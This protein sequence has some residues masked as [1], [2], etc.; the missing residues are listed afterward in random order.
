M[1]EDVCPSNTSK[2]KNANQRGCPI[3]LTPEDQRRMAEL[4]AEGLTC[5]QIADMFG[6]V[7]SCVSTTLRKLGVKMRVIGIRIPK[8]KHP[9]IIQM[10]E[11]GQS[12]DTIAKEFGCSHANIHRILQIHDVKMRPS[13]SPG[14]FSEDICRKIID[15]YKQGHSQDSIAARF[16][17]GKKAIKRVLDEHKVERRRHNQFQPRF[18]AEDH[19]RMVAMYEQG[20]SLQEIAEDI[21]CTHH[22][23][24][25]LL[26]QLG[27]EKRPVLLRHVITPEDREMIVKLR[28]QGKS[29]PEI[30]AKIGCCRETVIAIMRQLNVPVRIQGPDAYSDEDQQKMVDLYENG[31]STV[32][33]AVGFDCGTGTV[34]QILRK[35]GIKIRPHGLQGLLPPKKRKRMLTMYKEGYS[36]AEIAAKFECNLET[37]AS[38]IELATRKSQ[39]VQRIASMSN[40]NAVDNSTVNIES[41]VSETPPHIPLE[42]FIR[43]FWTDQV[44]AVDVLLLPPDFRLKIMES[45][46]QALVYAWTTQGSVNAR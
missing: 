7:V 10:Y 3:V 36:G 2:S 6:C 20:K 31:I 18:I 28:S 8:E 17:C 27:I 19:Q 39:I 4:Y 15:M 22:T 43:N 16:G 14:K 33:I 32:E 44:R 25:R 26:K 37:V 34:I 40:L 45:V 29:Y 46:K 5:Q 1:G 11:A 30:A 41:P 9:Q 35:L 38:M 13:T 21:G 12:C 42:T 24:R 23:V